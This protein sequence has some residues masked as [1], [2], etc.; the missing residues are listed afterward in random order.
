MSGSKEKFEKVFNLVCG[1]KQGFGIVTDTDPTISKV[2]CWYMFLEA[3]KQ[4]INIGETAVAIESGKYS[5]EDS[6]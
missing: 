5:K 4:N 6:Q 3:A 1:D 2:A